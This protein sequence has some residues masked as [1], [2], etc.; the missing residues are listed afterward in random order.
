MKLDHDMTFKNSMDIKALEDCE[1][2]VSYDF[3]QDKK[4]LSVT[5]FNEPMHPIDFKSELEMG[6]NMT[7]M[8][9][10]TTPWD[11]IKL[12]KSTVTVNMGSQP[13]TVRMESTLNQSTVTSEGKPNC[14]AL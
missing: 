2:K 13:W 3:T 12:V 10:M 1:F 9:E 14:A 4:T 6:D 11:A 7:A 8:V 5:A